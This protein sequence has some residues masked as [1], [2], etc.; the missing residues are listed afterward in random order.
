MSYSMNSP[1]GAGHQITPPFDVEPVPAEARTVRT[2]APEYGQL[3]EQAVNDAMSAR[4]RDHAA[5]NS[6]PNAFGR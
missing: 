2:T 4:D 5:A 6:V 1:E 3:C